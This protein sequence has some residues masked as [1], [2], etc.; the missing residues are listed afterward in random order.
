MHAGSWPD[1]SVDSGRD[2]PRDRPRPAPEQPAARRRVV[3]ATAADVVRWFGAVQS[4]DVP[5][6]MWARRPADAAR[7]RRVEDLGAAFDAGEIVRTHAMRPTWHFLAP[8][9]LRWIQALDRTRVAPGERP[10]NRRASSSTDDD[11]AHGRSA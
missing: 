7:R 1:R 11:F 9:E 2:Q 10:L 4:Q 5:G 3:A 6:A 8:D